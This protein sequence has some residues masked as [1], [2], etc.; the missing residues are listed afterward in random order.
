MT[1]DYFRRLFPQNLPVIYQKLKEESMIDL[2][3][4]CNSLCIE[5]FSSSFFSSKEA[6][7]LDK[8]LKKSIELEA[9]M[10]KEYERIFIKELKDFKRWTG[11]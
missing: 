2:M 9:Y 3:D 10:E 1:E 4:N 5:D 6:T 11:V 8:C 7:C